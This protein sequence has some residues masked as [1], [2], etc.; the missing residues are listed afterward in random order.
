MKSKVFSILFCLWSVVALAENILIKVIDSRTKFPIEGVEIYSFHLG[1][2]GI[3][4]REGKLVIRTKDQTKE[5]LTLFLPSYK[6]KEIAVYPKQKEEYII[7]MSPLELTLNQVILEEEKKKQFALQSLKPVVGTSIYAGKKSE[8]IL[9]DFTMGN[10]AVNNPRQIFAKV[11]GL[12]IYDSNDGGLQLNIGGRGLDPNRTANFNTRQNN[13]DISAD[14]LGYPESYYTPPTEALETIEI[15]RG[16][17]SLQYGTQFG[18]LVNFKFKKPSKAPYAITFRNTLGSFGLYTNFTQISGTKDKFSY[19]AMFNGKRGDGFRKNS[20][21]DSYFGFVQLNYHFTK[22]TK[23][24]LEATYFHYLA[25][26]AGGLSDVQFLEDPSQSFLDRN[27]FEVDWKLLSF[28]FHHQFSEFI[29]YSLIVSGLEASRKAVGFRGIQ[30]VDNPQLFNLKGDQID[31]QGQYISK[32]DL[33]LGN[34]QNISIETKLLTRYLIGDYYAVWMLGAKYYQGINSSQQGGGTKNSDADF[35]F[36]FD[37][38]KNDYPNQNEFDFPN[39]NLAL[40]GEHIFYL[41]KY[42]TLTPGVRYEY[43]KTSAE[44]KYFVPAQQQFLQDNQTLDRNFWLLG[45]GTSYK[46]THQIEL[47]QNLSQNYRSVTFSDIRTVNPS[48]IIDPNIEDEK[49]W[50]ADLGMRGKIDNQ[51]SYDI[52]VFSLY[53]GNRIGQVLNNRAQWIRK[54]IG[55]A[56]IYGLESL[57]QWDIQ[58]SFFLKMP[59]LELSAFS[60]VSYT[61]SKYLYSED[62]NVEGNKV[63]FIP[64]LNYKLGLN[65][66]YKNWLGTLQYSYTGEQFTDVTNSPYIPENNKNVIG[67]IPSYEILDLSSSYIFSKN[68]KLEFGINN[69][70]NKS[71]FTRRATGYPG[72]GIIP[73]EPLNVYTTLE[74]K[75]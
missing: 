26:Q 45:L 22:K 57:I 35:S 62:N 46:P 56:L 73:A 44:G 1:Y 4:D 13:Y 75:W 21:F 20:Q 39:Q 23:V 16:A 15:I 61:R 30:G 49:G 63:E 19:Q 40:F 69:L 38:Y 60:N 64:E 48:F 18:G 3:T 14:V 25:K 42:L 36:H 8:V 31:E 5:H 54:N 47:Y 24:G 68:I 17:A 53:Y 72:P 27:W 34:F 33:I 50:T 67:A 9:V 43:I 52:N 12:N 70:L 41:S 51:F 2:M 37:Q 71:Y 55:T 59:N 28:N 29:N 65:F 6:S 10:K 32:R 58:Q 7:E 11:S 74:V 66:G